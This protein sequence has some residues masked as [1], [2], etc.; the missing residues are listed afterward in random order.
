MS[1]QLRGDYFVCP[2]PLGLDSYPICENNCAFC[3]IKQRESGWQRKKAEKGLHPI[4]TI[5]MEKV[6]KK[7]FNSEKE[8]QDPIVRALRYGLPVTIGRR[9]EPLCKSET[10][11]RATRNCIKMLDDY[12]VPFLIE[13]R[14]VR[15]ALD[16]LNNVDVK[17]G[18]NISMLFGDESIHDRLEPGTSTYDQRWKLINDLNECSSAYVSLIA[19]PF[20]FTATDD[21]DVIRGYAQKAKEFSV[22]HVN[23]G[24]LRVTGGVIAFSERL[25]TAGVSLLKHF[26][27]IQEN[28]LSVGREIFEIFRHYGVPISSPDWVNF[29]QYNSCYSCCGLDK[30]HSSH[31]FTFQH[32][33]N[34][35]HATGS[36]DW[37][38]FVEQNIFGESHIEKVRKIWNGDE[39]YYTPADVE[40]IYRHGKDE[41]GNAIYALV[42]K[43]KSLK[44][45]FG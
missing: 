44:E 35:I 43:E 34:V 45:I 1:F 28:W 18:I 21:F 17:A 32:A 24:E 26:E 16:Y 10:K 2:N 9:S 15:H 41:N 23:F 33:L 13:T 22:K 37:D 27:L 30:F 39:R 3:F 6:L 19:E 12:H 31:H 42:P 4:P 11:H 25:K 7:A 14:E 40:G 38:T 29:N 5:E 20:I 36:I 8:Y